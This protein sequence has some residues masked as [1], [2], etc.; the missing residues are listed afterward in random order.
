VPV[1]FLELLWFAVTLALATVRPPSYQYVL[2]PLW[3][4]GTAIVVY[5]TSVEVF[6][7]HAICLYC[8]LADACALLLGAPVTRAAFSEE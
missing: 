5:L 1:A 6:V 2:F 8:T 7:I 3:V 4:A